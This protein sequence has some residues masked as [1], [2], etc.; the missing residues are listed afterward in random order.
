MNVDTARWR[1]CATRECCTV[2]DRGHLAIE[3]E[4]SSFRV[5]DIALVPAEEAVGLKETAHLLRSP[6]N[7]KRLLTALRRANRRSGKRETIRQLRRDLGLER[8][9]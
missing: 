1:A 3:T 7:A 8:S 9:N 5:R 6:K 2:E 4:L